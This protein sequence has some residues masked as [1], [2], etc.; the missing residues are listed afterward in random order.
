MVLTNFRI[1]LDFNMNCKSR[2]CKDNLKMEL[3]LAP[4]WRASKTEW[5]KKSQS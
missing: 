1:M 5:K 2:S 4:S 3:R